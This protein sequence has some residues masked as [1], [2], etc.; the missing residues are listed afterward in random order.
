MAQFDAKLFAQVSGAGKG[1]EGGGKGK[2]KGKKE[3]K[4]QPKKEE[5]KE[6]EE[7]EPA[8]KKKAEPFEGV[9]KS[10]FVMDDWKKKYSNND[11]NTA[12]TYFWDKLDREG[13]SLWKCSYKFPKELGM[14]IFASNLL[15]GMFQR[16]ESMKKYAFAGVCTFSKP[17]GEGH[18]MSGVWLWRGQSLIFER[19]DNWKVD[20]ESWDWE[21][22]DTDSDSTKDLVRKYFGWEEFGADFKEYSSKVYK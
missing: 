19:S 8:P 14:E 16:L 1:K 22:L 21:K 3:K 20:Y 5:K 11:I 17:K 15:G 12:L 9:P 2:D 6:E 7:E 18:D 13:Y 4:A 10:D